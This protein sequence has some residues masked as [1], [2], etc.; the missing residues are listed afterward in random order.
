MASFINIFQRLKNYEVD[1][2]PAAY[3]AICRELDID[4]DHHS[5]SLPN[6]FQQLNYHQVKPPAGAFRELESRI[7]QLPA[8]R[9]LDQR[10]IVRSLWF[11]TAGAAAAVLLVA[12]GVYTVSSGKK[13]HPSSDAQLV[14]QKSL[15]AP[16]VLPKEDSVSRDIVPAAA[17]SGIE[18]T[19]V[20]PQKADIPV[21]NNISYQAKV[22][23]S[24]YVIEDND[25]LSQFVSY[26]YDAIPAFITST[27]GAELTVEVDQY[28]TLKVSRSMRDMV[29]RM[30][31]YTSKDK[32]SRKS[33]KLRV[34]MQQWK[35]AD[36][37]HFD[38]GKLF[39]PIDPIDLTDFILK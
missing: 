37:V 34:K 12:L 24:P 5:I 4:P 28:A 36:E 38:N 10:K 31:Q 39:N 9:S 13:R 30:Y 2:P 6:P 15:P 22:M 25:F 19:V 11:R 3:R 8:V 20:A 14:R 32:L 1:P 27:R 33:R 17:D 29:R 23:G 26:H 21:P 18:S 7:G 35:D 16:V